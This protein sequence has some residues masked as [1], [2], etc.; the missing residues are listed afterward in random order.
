MVRQN[1]PFPSGNANHVHDRFPQ[2]LPKGEGPYQIKVS[3]MMLVWYIFAEHDYN[4][5][6][7]L[8]LAKI[9]NSG[10]EQNG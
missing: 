2:G 8:E 1:V 10:W 7:D 4:I 5:Q 3:R 9:T 6:P